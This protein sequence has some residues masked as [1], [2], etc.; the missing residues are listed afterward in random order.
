MSHEDFFETVESTKV[1]VEV[2][3][4]VLTLLKLSLT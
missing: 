1:F 2:H 3:L 4:V